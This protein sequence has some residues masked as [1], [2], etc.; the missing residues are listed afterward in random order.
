MAVS[1]LPRGTNFSR[2]CCSLARCGGNLQKAAG[3][4]ANRYGDNSV[5]A[6]ILRAAVGSG[7]SRPD[8]SW[9]QALAEVNAASTEFFNLVRE[10]SLLGRMAGVR[11]M[12]LAVQVLRSTVGAS[13]YWVSPGAAKPISR[14]SFA[15]DSLLP[16]KVAALSVLTNEVLFRGE[17]A[18]E[19]YIL[20]DMVA[21]ARE[22]QDLAFIDPLNSGVAEE[23][24]ASVTYGAT[25]VTGTGDPAADVASLIAAFSGDLSAAYFVMHPNT[26]AAIGLSRDSG[27]S[28]QFPDVGPRGGSILGMPVL[29]SRMVPIDSNGGIIALIDASGIAVGEGVTEVKASSH[30]SIEMDSEPNGDSV[31]PTGSE[32]VSLYQTNSTALLVESEINWRAVRSGSVAIIEGA[33]YG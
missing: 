11:R 4:A 25:A 7:S 21:A 30:A 32:M 29:T 2:Y 19:R 18:S 15:R 10:S 23:S 1:L 6:L 28:F 33:V 14:M 22:V 26:A 3:D 27:G 24:P 17:A 31:T 5:P 8:A 16:L 13:A 20:N 12:P 9:G